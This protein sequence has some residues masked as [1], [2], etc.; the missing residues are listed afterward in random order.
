MKK[1]KI[2]PKTVEEDLASI[3]ESELL[4]SKK[5]IN[6]RTKKMLILS[7][8][9]IIIILFLSLIY[10]QY[11]LFNIIQGQI[12]SRSVNNNVLEMK[13][14]NVVFTDAALLKIRN[15]YAENPEVETSLCLI[16]EKKGTDYFISD[17]YT[18]VIFEQSFRH[19]SHQAC[20]SSTIIM[21]H[22]HPYKSCVASDT[23]LNTLKRNQLSNPDMLTIVMCQPNRYSVYR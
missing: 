23:D 22:T 5:E 12:E 14:F 11:P 16:G 19:V 8:G 6:P 9:T 18:P 1:E 7:G 17:A 2:K 21:F 20:N 10:L 15:S 3:N 13:D 4:D